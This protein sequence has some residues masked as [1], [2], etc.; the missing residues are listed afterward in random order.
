MTGARP[1]PTSA[2]V[3]F[4]MFESLRALIHDEAQSPV[5]QRFERATYRQGDPNRRL[6]VL[7]FK[8]L[9]ALAAADGHVNLEE[10]NLLKDFA[11]EHSLTEEEW[12]EIQYYA[13]APLSKDALAELTGTVIAEVRTRA[14]REQFA[15]AIKEMANGIGSSSMSSVRSSRSATRSSARCTCQC[16]ATSSRRSGLPGAAG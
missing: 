4:A 16:W 1:F 3:V 2:K 15:S 5:E 12:A 10:I 13:T 11:F 6:Q 14:D 9:T 8:L 7:F